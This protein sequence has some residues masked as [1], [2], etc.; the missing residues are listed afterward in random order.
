MSHTFVKSKCYVLKAVRFKLHIYVKQVF[1]LIPDSN[2]KGCWGPLG[3]MGVRGG[4][5]G[6]RGRPWA[7]MGVRGRPIN[8]LGVSGRKI[9]AAT[10]VMYLKQL[11]SNYI[12]M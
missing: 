10:N 12:F 6:V 1:S 8:A 5:L 7:F 3:P 4:S 11:D 2:N 9:V